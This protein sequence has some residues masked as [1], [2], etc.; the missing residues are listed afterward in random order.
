MLF[1]FPNQKESMVKILNGWSEQTLFLL[2]FCQIY[3]LSTLEILDHFFTV[4]ADSVFSIKPFFVWNILIVPFLH[5]FLF[6]QEY[7]LDR[8]MNYT[9]KVESGSHIEDFFNQNYY[10]YWC[11][12]DFALLL[13]D[14]SNSENNRYTQHVYVL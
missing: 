6:F 14:K 1:L 7:F 4:F 10:C 5:N 2:L 9:E 3:S 11:F 13:V 12:N 8:M